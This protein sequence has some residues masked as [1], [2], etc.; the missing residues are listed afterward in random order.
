MTEGLRDLFRRRSLVIPYLFVVAAGMAGFVQASGARNDLS[1]DIEQRQWEMCLTSNDTRAAIRGA[2][3]SYTEALV[4]AAA[5]NDQPAEQ[6]QLDSFKRLIDRKLAPL[7]PRDCSV[8][9][10]K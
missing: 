9:K 5:A 1:H 8:L 2:F 7:A 6:A 4:E 3:D 10:P